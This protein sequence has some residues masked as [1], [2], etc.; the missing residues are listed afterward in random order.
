ML[1]ERR[2]KR[3]YPAVIHWIDLQAGWNPHFSI[4]SMRPVSPARAG[5]RVRTPI[6][7]LI[8]QRQPV[9]MRSRPSTDNAAMVAVPNFHGRG[10][11]AA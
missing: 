6:P 5:L 7:R 4:R 8:I 9:T 10:L 1:R 2:F 11:D 3:E